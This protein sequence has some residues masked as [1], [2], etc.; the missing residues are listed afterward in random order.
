MTEIEK[1]PI[2]L[3]SI[4]EKVNK[5]DPKVTQPSGNKDIQKTKG[6]QDS[7]KNNPNVINSPV[8]IINTKEDVIIL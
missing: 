3:P 1:I 2:D 4:P 5:L 7:K 6:S 8:N